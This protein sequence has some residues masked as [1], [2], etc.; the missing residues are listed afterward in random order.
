[1]IFFDHALL[2]HTRVGR[3][4][5]AAPK[6]LDDSEQPLCNSRIRQAR[7]SR[8]LGYGHVVPIP[9]TEQI[10][11]SR[12]QCVN[13]RCKEEIRLRQDCTASARLQRN[14][15]PPLAKEVDRGIAH[16]AHQVRVGRLGFP[17]RLD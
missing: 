6:I 9:L 17:Y 14:E 15:M 11:L 8:D 10:P 12:R 3:K 4:S 5:H 1:M 2:V 16:H 13:N 7:F